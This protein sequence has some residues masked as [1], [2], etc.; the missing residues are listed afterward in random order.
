MR[1]EC[2]KSNTTKVEVDKHIT[3]H[4]MEKQYSCEPCGKAFRQNF[5]F[6]AYKN[7]YML[8]AIYV[9]SVSKQSHKVQLSEGMLKRLTTWSK[10]AGH[11][12]D[13]KTTS[14]SWRRT[15]W[16]ILASLA[17]YWTRLLPVQHYLNLKQKNPAYRRHQISQPVQIVAL[18][19]Q[20]WIGC[21]IY[22]K[23][24]EKKKLRS[25]NYLGG[26]QNI[27]FLRGGR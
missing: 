3:F 2:G 13:V 22:L 14:D 5:S 27:F 16:S 20:I 15:S 21:M 6:A 4:I 18:I 19:L 10:E 11:S 7:C 1:I 17:L 8:Y 26:V 9:N 23:E 12:F 24:K 25:K